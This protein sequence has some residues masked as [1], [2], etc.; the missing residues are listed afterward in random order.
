MERRGECERILPNS[1]QAA[2]EEFLY[3]QFHNL[4]ADQAL[5]Q[6]PGGTHTR[7]IYNMDAAAQSK[8]KQQKLSTKST[9]ESLPGPVFRVIAGFAG[10]DRYLS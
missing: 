6:D 9:V 8:P 4:E 5:S 10:L 3:I 1:S 2:H 7:V